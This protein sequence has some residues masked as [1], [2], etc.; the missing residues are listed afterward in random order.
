[1]ISMFNDKKELLE[2]LRQEM[3][4]LSAGKK[5]TDPQ[6]INISKKMDALLNKYYQT[7]LQKTK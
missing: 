1:M 5:L 7:N 3:Y 2:E 4:K 6:V